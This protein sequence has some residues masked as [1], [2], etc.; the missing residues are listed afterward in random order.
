MSRKLTKLA[1]AGVAAASLIFTGCK[2][3]PTT[4]QLNALEEARS[5]AESAEQLKAQ[6]KKERM[7][8]EQQVAGRQGVLKGHEAER[9]D[10]KEKMA[11][12]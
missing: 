3:K 1:I 12:R 9:D 5:A 8:L 6:K 11:A 2:A 10:L 4:E 7:N